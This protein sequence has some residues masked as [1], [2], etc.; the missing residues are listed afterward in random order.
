LY[1]N[2]EKIEDT[3]EFRDREDSV[4]SSIFSLFL[5]N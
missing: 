4:E 5:Y 3:Y 2:K 1:K